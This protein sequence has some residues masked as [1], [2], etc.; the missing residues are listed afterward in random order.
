MRVKGRPSRSVPVL[1][2]TAVVVVGSG[3]SGMI[4]AI[5]SARAGAETMLVERY[6]Q[7]GG[8]FSNRPGGGFGL[9]FHDADGNQIIR[10]VPWELVDRVLAAGGGVPPKEMINRSDFGWPPK[11]AYGKDRPN[12]DFESVKT[13]AFQMMEEDGVTL[14]LHAYGVGAVVEDGAV[15]GIIIESKSGRQA[16]LAKVVVDATGDADIA[17]QAGAPFEK[18]SRDV[19]YQVQ[20][21]YRLGNVDTER[22]RQEIKRNLEEY[23]DVSYPADEMAIPAGFQSSITAA[24]VPEGSRKITSEDGTS[25]FISRSNVTAGR[26]TQRRGMAVGIRPG[27]GTVIAAAEADATDVEDL[28]KAELDIRKQVVEGVRW[29]RD[30]APG[31]ENC[32]LMG[33]GEA[34]QLG[35]RET[36]RIV[37]EYTLTEDDI[38]GGRK[39]DDSIGKSA[40]SIDMH[41]HKGDVDVRGVRGYHDIPYGTLVP[42][43]IDNILAAGRCI[44]ATHVAE[45]ATRKVPVCMVTGQA[46]G[47]AA[48]L[49]AR[50]GVAPRGL[51]VSEVQKTLKDLGN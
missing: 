43:Q 5:A 10:G 3:P 11:T 14:L 45:A 46:A 21:C 25:Y 2:K 13:T 27:T 29:L 23:T 24:V 47:V 48:A 28:T 19:L 20:R 41:L 36:R 26:S 6:G 22:I 38:T 17:A 34:E 4:A 8:Y 18:A 39:F 40:N 49:S 7:I 50:A 33:M 1:A 30:N 37:G 12:L 16:V 42:K 31:Y 51:S 44:S 32:Y 15:K 35:V 9:A